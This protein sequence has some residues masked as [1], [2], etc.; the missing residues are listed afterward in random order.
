M[1][2]KSSTISVKR[3]TNFSLNSTSQLCFSNLLKPILLYTSQKI[4]TPLQWCEPLNSSHQHAMSLTMK[5][6]ILDLNGKMSDM[7]YDSDGQQK[8]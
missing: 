8:W 6:Q 1:L 7:G 3:K 2:L 5:Q 4:L